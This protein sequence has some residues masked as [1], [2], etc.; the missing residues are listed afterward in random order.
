MEEL[1]HWNSALTE[2]YL[3]GG[4]LASGT[5]ISA[6]SKSVDK[7][8]LKATGKIKLFQNASDHPVSP[9]D[10]KGSCSQ[11]LRA[12]RE[13]KGTRFSSLHWRHHKSEL[14]NV[15]QKTYWQCSIAGPMMRLFSCRPR[16]YSQG[17]RFLYNWLFSFTS[18][19]G[20]RK[21]VSTEDLIGQ[22][23]HLVNLFF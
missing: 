7:K 19:E 5:C 10:A 17:R 20:N 8:T 18:P 21:S 11:Y 23:R 6:E 16:F 22:T 4:I 2:L 12:L 1:W 13:G 9:V 15:C 14:W 3:S